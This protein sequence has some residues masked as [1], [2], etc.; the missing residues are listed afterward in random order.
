MERRNF[1]KNFGLAGGM[2]AIPSSI[3]TAASAT[4]PLK[5][6]L[7][8]LTLKGKVHNNGQAVTGV[9]V[10]DGFNVTVT[11]KN[12]YYELLSNN[13]AEHVYISIPAG[14]AFTNEK[15]IAD[16]YRPITEKKGF[17]KSDFNL[18]KLEMDDSKHN[19]VVWA[20]THLFSS[21]GHPKIRGQI[22]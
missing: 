12:G 1:L 16:F 18:E 10:T 9:A 20:D 6:D 11:D 17:F 5:K 8:N 7:S 4:E 15:G 22:I 13:S 21:L 14:Y 19:F 3:V 2:F